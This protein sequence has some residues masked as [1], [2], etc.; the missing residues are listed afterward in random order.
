MGKKNRLRRLLTV[1]KPKSTVFDPQ[2][3]LKD[4]TA[5]YNNAI[6]RASREADLR[7]QAGY[8]PSPVNKEIE[9]YSTRLAAQKNKPQELQKM[10]YKTVNEQIKP[11]KKGGTVKSKKTSYGKVTGMAKKK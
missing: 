8:D 3:Y 6:N 11:K 9:F 1:E 4:S 5:Y 10:G 7:R 2:A